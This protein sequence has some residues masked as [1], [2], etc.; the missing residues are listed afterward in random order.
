MLDTGAIVVGAS[1][2]GLATSACL[3]KQKREHVLLEASD[4]VGS[5]WRGHYERLHLHTP[6]SGS[7]LPFVP[8]APEVP[9]YPSRLDVSSDLPARAARGAVVAGAAL[10][11]GARIDLRSTARSGSSR[12]TASAI[13]RRISSSRPASRACR[14]SRRGRTKISSPASSCTARAIAA[15]RRTPASAFS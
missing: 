2:A 14:I 12:P 1:A 7:S 11:E 6:K 3:A 8:F 15:A 10:N 9:R 4:R 5:A 13:A